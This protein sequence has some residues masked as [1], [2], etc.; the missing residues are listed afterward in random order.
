[1]PQK[2]PFELQ[3][4][5]L[6]FLLHE[7]SMIGSWLFQGLDNPLQALST[8]RAPRALDLPAR[9]AESEK[10]LKVLRETQ[11]EAQSMLQKF[12]PSPQAAASQASQLWKNAQEELLKWQ[13]AALRLESLCKKLTLLSGE[14]KISVLAR[15]P[16]AETWEEAQALV[17]MTTKS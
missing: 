2:P 8:G 5:R 14:E 4:D 16:L 7:I 15:K 1:M 9:V 17:L 3:L 13:E 10:L 12:Q 11:A 6:R